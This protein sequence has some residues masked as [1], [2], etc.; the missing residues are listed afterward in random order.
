[1]EKMDKTNR[2]AKKRIL[3][4]EDEE[5]S[6]YLDIFREQ[7]YEAH[8][9]LDERAAISVLTSLQPEV[10]LLDIHLK[11]GGSGIEIL[12]QMKEKNFSSHEGYCMDRT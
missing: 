11:K 3:I 1:M 8:H 4:V 9:A 2:M 12:K 10:M 5:M 6:F 7:G